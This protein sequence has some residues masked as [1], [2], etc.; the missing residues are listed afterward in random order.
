MGKVKKSTKL[1]L[2]K[3]EKD[4]SK[5]HGKPPKQPNHSK[6]LPKLKKPVERDE[7]GSE[8]EEGEVIPLAKATKKPH[9]VSR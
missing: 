5:K 8:S 6:K 7:D 1:Y 9:S 4:K 2:Q 3:Q